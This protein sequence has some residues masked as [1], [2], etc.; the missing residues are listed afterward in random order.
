MKKKKIGNNLANRYVDRRQQVVTF[1][2]TVLEWEQGTAIY[3][4]QSTKNQRFKHIGSAE[5]QTIQL[6][7]FAYRAGAPKNE[8]TILYDENIGQEGMYKDASGTL[9]I[10]EREGLS[11]LC[12][13]IENGAKVVVC[14]LIDRLFCD[15]DMI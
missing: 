6:L 4:R 9:R 3:A 13:Y 2:Q 7:E 14:F 15:E 12:E 5:V 8:K 11:A 10:D 1:G